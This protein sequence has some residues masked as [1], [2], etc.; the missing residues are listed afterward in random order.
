MRKIIL[1]LFVFVSL[2]AQAQDYHFSQF[3]STPIMLNPASAGFFRGD[4]RLITNYRRQWGGVTNPYKTM[5]VSYDMG[6]WRDKENTKFLA[7]GINFYSDKA[8]D[9]N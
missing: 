2:V 6:V 8:G 1:S 9:G 7:A 4:Y 3:Y 5:A